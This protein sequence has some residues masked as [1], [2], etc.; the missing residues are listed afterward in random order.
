MG[1]AVAGGV[2]PRAAKGAAMHAVMGAVARWV[3]GAAKGVGGGA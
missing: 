2:W 1:G 3:M